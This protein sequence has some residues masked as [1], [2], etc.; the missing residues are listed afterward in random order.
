M[1]LFETMRLENGTIPRFQYHTHRIEQSSARLGFAFSKEKWEQFVNHIRHQ[2]ERGIY[3]L[4]VEID[5]FGHLEY[6]IKSLPAKT[7][8]TAKLQV[9]DSDC[10]ERYIINKTSERQHLEHNHQTD[11]VLLYSNNGKI[12][13]FDIGNVMI[14]E[15][16]VYY[17]PSYHNDFLLGCMR[18]SLL[19]QQKLEIKDYDVNE[20]VGKLKRNQ[21][22]VYLLNSLR[23]V[24]EVS[25]YL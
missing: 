1:R 8:F 2:H 13:E 17:T 14:E 18:Q 20:L 6:V 7:S 24:A 23:E 5:Q 12:L 9:M 16:G 10:D 15:R 11:L 22:H 19:D 3:R 21:I 25:I 4:K